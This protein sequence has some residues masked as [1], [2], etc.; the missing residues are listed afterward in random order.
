MKQ[1]KPAQIKWTKIF[2]YYYKYSKKY[3]VF[4]F[5]ILLGYG[6]GVVLTSALVPYI[7]KS[8]VDII[9]TPEIL[10][11]DRILLQAELFKYIFYVIGAL[12][13][14]RLF[15]II[16]D[17]SITYFQNK[18]LRDLNNFTFEVI[19][20]HSYQ[21]FINSFTGS[22]VKKAGRFVNSFEDIGD[23][24]I[25]NIFV[26]FI[27]ITS[28]FGILFYVEPIL[29]LIFLSWS[30][31]FILVSYYLARRKIKY[32]LVEAEADSHLTA[33]ASDVFTN[34]LN[35]KMFSSIVREVLAFNTVA[36]DQM[37]ARQKA[38]NYQNFVYI[39]Q[40]AL[41]MWLQVFSLYAVVVLWLDGIVSVGT[42]ILVIAYT[43][44]ILESIW[45]LGKQL[46]RLSKAFSNA[47]EM[48]EIIEIPNEISDLQTPE[49]LKIKKGHVFFENVSFAYNQGNEIF[50]DFNMEISAGEKVGI[51]GTS[52]A[53]KSTITK[54][55]LRFADVT[56]GAIK[57]DGQDIRNITQD[58]L[59]SV[60]SYVPQDPILFHRSLSENISYGKIDA[61][62]KE[63]V[64]AS[65]KAHADD[66]ISRLPNKYE[67]MVG[68]RGVKLSGGER[69][70][71]ALARAIL[72]NAPILIL[73]E[74]T[75][76][77]DSESEKYIQESL[78]LLMKGKTTI[79]IAHRLSTIQKMDRIIV[80]ENGEIAEEGSH[81]VLL[82][83]K[84]RYAK[85]WEHQS[86]GFLE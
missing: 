33:R 59:R 80:L 13:G 83:K 27:K 1:N 61:E 14:T 2:S 64:S 76:S 50:S 6:V 44:T 55:M 37:V 53:G 12:I 41:V 31:V 24:F 65:K 5:L 78:D 56:K 77:L 28:V 70:R 73:D 29:G 26:S 9:S 68:E 45:H 48:V 81:A 22:L 67:T 43:D 66:F 8:I 10:S 40:G 11:G 32:D 39:L 23:I 49:K 69:Q 42:I 74:A 51:V 15:F 18:V 79:V 4:F 17:Y 72:K 36:T 86:G 21:F 46:T 16:G 84:G 62:T 3:G 57:I 25:Y 34:A 20:K 7:Y 35:L 85:L 82:E 30:L 60:I 71:V 58:D 47:S 54:L 63:I 75:S 38:W 52:G 19:L